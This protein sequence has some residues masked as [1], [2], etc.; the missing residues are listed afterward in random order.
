MVVVAF[1]HPLIQSNRHLKIK[2]KRKGSVS[3][4]LLD[5]AYL[6]MKK[7]GENTLITLLQMQDL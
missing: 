7:V 4:K 6:F 1:I 5:I 3:D 2:I